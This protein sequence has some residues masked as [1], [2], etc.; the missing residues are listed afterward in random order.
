MWRVA[1]ICSNVKTEINTEQQN[2]NNQTK[3]KGFVFIQDR[4]IKYHQQSCLFNNTAAD[5]SFISSLRLKTNPICRSQHIHNQDVK[6]TMS[7]RSN[8]TC[9]VIIVIAAWFADNDDLYTLS[10]RYDSLSFC[11]SNKIQEI[12]R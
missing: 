1:S 6:F 5:W 12:L 7:C 2:P 9:D 3:I 10:K 11:R 8:P 4:V